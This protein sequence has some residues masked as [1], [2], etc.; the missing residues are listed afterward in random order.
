MNRLSDYLERKIEELNVKSNEDLYEITKRDQFT[1]YD[2]YKDRVEKC[3]SAT[4]NQERVDKGSFFMEPSAAVAWEKH[5]KSQ[6]TQKVAAIT[7]LKDKFEKIRL[8]KKIE[9]ESKEEAKE[10]EK[11][12]EEGGREEGNEK[13]ETLVEEIKEN[14]LQE[15]NKEEEVYIPVTGEKVIP[16]VDFSKKE[17]RVYLR[18]KNLDIV[19]RNDA[20]ESEA[21]NY[22]E[23]LQD[24]TN[25]FLSD[26][27]LMVEDVWHKA[28][29]S[30]KQVITRSI[31]KL[32]QMFI[33]IMGKLFSISSKEKTI[34]LFE[35]FIAKYK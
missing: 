24:K 22:I 2:E 32:F 18:N 30:S 8:K 23:K 31:D 14:F 12:I 17:V 25:K 11:E 20:K 13:D 1:D 28:E 3:G 35:E 16:E 19:Q 5:N 7:A 6:Q 29:P 34:S 21:L 33:S 4:P 10:K 9:E 27:S 15:E 26:Y